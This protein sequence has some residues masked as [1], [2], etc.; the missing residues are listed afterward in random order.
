MVTVPANTLLRE[1]ILKTDPD[2]RMPAILED[3]DWSTWL[4]EN[5][6]PLEQVK[7]T[8]RAMEGENWTIAPE[9]KVTNPPKAKAPS[10][11][12]KPKPP[13]LFN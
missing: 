4:G 9:P 13:T 7:A 6:P 10:K 12:R 3:Q 11:Q 2:P 5:D 8:L 1:T